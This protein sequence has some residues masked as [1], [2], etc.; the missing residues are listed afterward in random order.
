MGFGFFLLFLAGLAFVMLQGRQLAQQNAP[1]GGSS[2]TGISWRPVFV[3]ADE[4]PENSGMFVKFE[5]DGSINGHGGCN[6]FSGSIEK[7]DAGTAIGPLAS[8]R[9]ACPEPIMNR[10]A[11]FLEA[12]QNTRHFGASPKRLQLLSEDRS[13]LVELVPQSQS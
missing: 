6:S 3:G 2:F 1:G 7:S 5:V 10:E 8:T 4:I 13:L 9:M 12:L 11:A